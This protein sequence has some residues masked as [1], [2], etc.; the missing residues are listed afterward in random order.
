MVRNLTARA[1]APFEPADR[2][3]DLAHQYTACGNAGG[4]SPL[5]QIAG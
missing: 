5:H 4:R 2:R 3:A 1:V